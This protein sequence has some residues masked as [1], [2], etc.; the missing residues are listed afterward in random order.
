MAA[1]KSGPKFNIGSVIFGF[2]GI[3][4]V[5]TVVLYLTHKDVRTYMVTA[6]T[7]S[8]NETYTAFVLR[9]ER[10]TKATAGGY[11][12]T[13]IA[14]GGKASRG[15]TVC[16]ISSSPESIE[17]VPPT[18]QTLNLIRRQLHQFSSYYD[19]DQFAQVYDLGYSLDASLKAQDSG[20]KVS[21]TGYTAEADG[22]IC[23]STDGYESMTI[24]GLKGADFDTKN[25]KKM[26]L[27]A[28][29]SV[30]A[31]D[32]L[33]R[34]IS[35]ESWSIVFP[36]SERQR[37]SLEG[38]DSIRI[39]FQKDQ[40]SE[41]GSLNLFERDGQY[42]AQVTF[43]DGLVRYCNDRYL[44]IELVTNT[45]SGLKVPL[46]SVVKKEFYKIPAS[47]MTFGGENGN[48][49]FMTER[50]DAE[51]N[52][53]TL[54][55]TTVLYDKI[56]EEEGNEESAAYLVDPNDF[57]PGDV[58]VP[59]DT[60]T[61]YEIGPTAELEGVYNVNKG[62]AIFRRILI[63]DQNEEYCIVESGTDYGIAQFDYIVQRGDEV[64]EDEILY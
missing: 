35:G 24:A 56:Y 7:L 49:G 63:L 1:R 32:A 8:G 40:N 17:S 10:V 18:Q 61:R 21:G 54:H 6:G 38:R 51:G 60:N 5:I 59:P 36:V 15:D 3:Y 12:N 33:Y 42:Y 43:D 14:D 16:S 27:R 2:I 37:V 58:I 53:T 48:A 64:T 19:S 31:G 57:Q 45:K 28:Q 9:D 20:K 55:V 47:Y 11:L 25:Y 52:V 44:D 39:L 13:Y 30:N 46:S 22:L 23:F 34:L 26:K 50:R 29:E 62:Y 4:L 41:V